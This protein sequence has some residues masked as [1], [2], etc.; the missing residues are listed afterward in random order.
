MIQYPTF[1][2]YNIIYFEVNNFFSQF[3]RNELNS[4]SAGLITIEIIFVFLKYCRKD[5]PNINIKGYFLL[6]QITK[7]QKFMNAIE[8]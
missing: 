2:R 7:C 5:T 4:N 3:E 1:K 8:K 6:Y